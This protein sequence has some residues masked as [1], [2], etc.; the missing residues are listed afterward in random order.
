M[1]TR[2]YRGGGVAGSVASRR[3][4]LQRMSAYDD[5]NGVESSAGVLPSAAQLPPRS[6]RSRQT[7]DAK[8]ISELASPDFRPLDLLLSQLDARLLHSTSTSGGSPRDATVAGTGIRFSAGNSEDKRHLEPFNSDNSSMS[9]S[10]DANISGINAAN[11]VSG[12]RG[13]GAGSARL[14][15]AR[16]A[17][18]GRIVYED[19]EEASRAV[20]EMDNLENDLM[21]L[22]EESKMNEEYAK[23]ELNRA[24]TD[25]S[26]LKAELNLSIQSIHTQLIESQKNVSHAAHALDFIMKPIQNGSNCK[27]ALQLGLDAAKLMQQSNEKFELNR[28][29]FLLSKLAA[30]V[31][32]ATDSEAGGTE[33]TIKNTV[34]G[35]ANGSEFT[36]NLNKV[37]TITES[38]GSAMD[39]AREKIAEWT[40]EL[41]D[42]L[43][44]ALL[45]NLHDIG[46]TDRVVGRNES[47]PDENERMEHVRE[48]IQAAIILNGGEKLIELY[49]HELPV[50]REPLPMVSTL[51]RQHDGAGLAGRSQSNNSEL[52]VVVYEML[53]EVRSELFRAMK[54]VIP[55]V[56]DVFE[57]RATYALHR[58]SA[59]LIENRMIRFATILADE[60]WQR[61]LLMRTNSDASNADDSMHCAVGEYLN[62]MAEAMR[63]IQECVKDVCG[64][65][66][67][68]GVV[69]ELGMSQLNWNA[70]REH[71]IAYP[72]AEIAWLESE[73]A[74]IFSNVLENAST[75]ESPFT[76]SQKSHEESPDQNQSQPQRMPSS[77]A[78]TK[79]LHARFHAVHNEE[80][81]L[82]TQ[83]ALHSL[84]DSLQRSQ[85]VLSECI[86]PR[87]PQPSTL[88]SAQP[89]DKL[90]TFGEENHFRKE[91][92]FTNLRE[93]ELKLSSAT[94][95]GVLAG[96]TFSASN[97]S[98]SLPLR[99]RLCMKLAHFKLCS[100]FIHIF[101]EIVT[102]A[103]SY[104][105][106]VIP[107]TLRSAQSLD[108]WGLGRSPISIFAASIEELQRSIK[109]TKEF[110]SVT[111]QNA[112]EDV[113]SLTS[114]NADAFENQL[115]SSSA[116]SVEIADELLH[117]MSRSLRSL[118]Y[119]CE[120]G[121]EL[122]AQA[123]AGR[124]L[125]LLRTEFARENPYL[126]PSD[127]ST[128]KLSIHQARMLLNASQF[129]ENGEYSALISTYGSNAMISLGFHQLVAFTLEQ[130]TSLKSH[131]KG[132]R[133]VQYATVLI[134]AWIRDAILTSWRSLSPG[135]GVRGAFQMLTDV[136]ALMDVFD[137]DDAD[138]E[139]L[140]L[141]EVALV[142]G[143]DSHSLNQ[144]VE[145]GALR[146]IDPV[147][148]TELIQLRADYPSNP[149]IHRLCSA[150]L[151]SVD[152]RNHSHKVLQ[153]YQLSTPN[154]IATVTGNTGT[155]GNI[156]RLP[157][158]HR[159]LG[160]SHNWA[161]Q[162]SEGFVTTPTRSLAKG[163]NPI[164]R[165]AF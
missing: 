80:L 158:S 84:E 114:S 52:V 160:Q 40:L 18:I 118:E 56:L 73:L 107:S 9:S 86:L 77:N 117:E 161:M 45:I 126:F 128:P 140:V 99:N 22:L 116:L 108:S 68:A 122:C 1:G 94:T 43:E 76:A 12:R 53:S 11:A 58:I 163:S 20:N 66:E 67:E 97:K 153:D 113:E 36:R 129:D 105:V 111:P 162:S 121:L 8:I 132:S 143:C 35:D 109:A 91:V 135:I 115:N 138:H 134:S 14:R 125:N 157:L 139:L 136:D 3:V 123:I 23:D 141:R 131:L 64:L 137:S 42:Y 33:E 39:A 104:G 83:D 7:D 27:Q 106:A 152:I 155:P 34:D 149:S 150:L 28:A 79:A 51:I 31:A 15:A 10:T 54:S 37:E 74:Y 87:S 90:P 46:G 72:S 156:A 130:M 98:S 75:I 19:D 144:W 71:I 16:R 151:P 65:C 63:V 120:R 13:V 69:V 164:S 44:Q 17:A 146:S 145:S 110:F 100:R 88:S 147:T 24:I 4:P 59:R 93:A 119:E 50:M 103:M 124:T 61:I 89:H 62:S 101:V 55:R 112:R 57:D 148:L 48:C 92:S 30:V 47:I 85:L 165:L 21:R 102:Q 5:G 41:E 70:I 26:R 2:G 32:T 159:S 25:A 49:A 95:P 154:L 82:M 29:A 133:N 142:F 81:G 127:S 96:D 60:L 38:E 6:G 78:R